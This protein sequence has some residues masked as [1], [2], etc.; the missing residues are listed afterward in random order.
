[1]DYLR[2]WPLQHYLTLKLFKDNKLP[3]FY[4]H[5]SEDRFVSEKDALALGQKPNRKSDSY[6][7]VGPQVVINAVYGAIAE[8]K[9]PVV[10]EDIAALL[11]KNQE[12]DPFIRS[13]LEIERKKTVQVLPI[14]EKEGPTTPKKK[15]EDIEKRIKEAME[16][17]EFSRISTVAGKLKEA[18]ERNKCIKLDTGGLVNKN[19]NTYILNNNDELPFCLA[20][21]AKDYAKVFAFYENKVN[22]ARGGKSQER[23]EKKT[24]ENG[25]IKRVEDLQKIVNVS[26]VR[27]VQTGP[28]VHVGVP[29]TFQRRMVD[30]PI[31]GIP[32]DFATL[33]ERMPTTRPQPSETYDALQML[34]GEKRSGKRVVDMTSLPVVTERKPVIVQVDRNQNPED[35][36]SERGLS[37]LVTGLKRRQPIIQKEEMIIREESNQEEEFEEGSGGEDEDVVDY[38]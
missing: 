1:M 25:K 29:P 33:R 37:G 2:N 7:L 8:K 32:S 12:A 18:I 30:V 27:T 24:S 35:V 21:G 19:S 15:E 3:V 10:P 23:S 20:K 34:Q 11:K 36:D 4:Y 17:D 22:E 6:L 26:P 31:E 16:K 9:I 28:V 38:E 13:L 14:V 5:V